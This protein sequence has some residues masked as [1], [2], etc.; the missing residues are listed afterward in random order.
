SQKSKLPLIVGTS[1]IALMLIGFA[2][3]AT[4][5]RKKPL[6]HEIAQNDVR[7]EKP[8][9]KDHNPVGKVRST[10]PDTSPKVEKKEVVEMKKEETK[11]EEKKEVV[12]LKKEEPKK[13]EKKEEPKKEEKEEPKKEAKKSLEFPSIAGVWKEQEKIQ[14]G[15]TQEADRFTA[16]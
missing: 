14:V 6:P 7:D 9:S 4:V 8:R 13:E 2:I 11:K 12:E 1:A 10:D 5:G 15:I 3:A 16:N